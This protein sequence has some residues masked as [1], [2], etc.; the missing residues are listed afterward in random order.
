MSGGRPQRTDRN[1]QRPGR[2]ERAEVRQSAVTGLAGLPPHERQAQAQG[3]RT[4]LLGA[5]KPGAG[6]RRQQEAGAMGKLGRKKWRWFQGAEGTG[7]RRRALPEQETEEEE[8]EGQRMTV[9]GSGWWRPS[10]LAHMAPRASLRT[11]PS[12][13]P[14]GFLFPHAPLGNILG[15]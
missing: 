10:C 3:D 2:R 1:R 7:T 11:Q 12:R 15:W 8:E 4:P 14:R 13:W 9:W 5:L 6:S